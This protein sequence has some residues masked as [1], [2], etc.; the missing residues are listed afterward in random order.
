MAMWAYSTRSCA[1]GHQWWVACDQVAAMPPQVEIVRVKVGPDWHCAHLDR[2]RVVDIELSLLRECVASDVHDCPDCAPAAE[3]EPAATAPAEAAQGGT[4]LQ[5]AAIT[6]AGR[7]MVVVLVPLELIE[8]P[9]EAEM[10]ATDLRPRFGGADIVLMG[11]DDD[12]TPHHHGE[13]GLLDLLAG[14]P[15]DRLPWRTYPLG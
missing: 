9:G 5:A 10:L 3:V 1:D 7:R 13:A 6:I 2:S 15:L 8:S 14:V 12:G 4:G 11:Q